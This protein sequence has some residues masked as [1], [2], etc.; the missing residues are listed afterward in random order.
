MLIP[1]GFSSPDLNSACHFSVAIRFQEY[2]G[3]TI[4]GIFSF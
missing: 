1:V 4:I 3:A 2:G